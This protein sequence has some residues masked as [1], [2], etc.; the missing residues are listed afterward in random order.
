VNVV[1]YSLSFYI[2]H[3]KVKLA[4]FKAQHIYI[5]AIDL[6]IKIYIYINCPLSG[7]CERWLHNEVEQ[8]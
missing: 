5:Y 3:V 7:G 6:Q 1:L 8:V 2:P 4:D